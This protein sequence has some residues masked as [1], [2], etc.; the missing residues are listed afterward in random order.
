MPVTTIEIAIHSLFDRCNKG[1]TII[2]NFR[3]RWLEHFSDA[4]YT[5]GT[6][7]WYFKVFRNYLIGITPGIIGAVNI[8]CVYKGGISTAVGGIAS[9]STFF[10]GNV[11]ATVGDG[12]QGGSLDIRDAVNRKGIVGCWREAFWIQSVSESPDGVIFGTV[13]IT[14]A[15]DHSSCS[16]GIEDGSTVHEDRLNGITTDILNDL[17]GWTADI[18]Q[19]GH[20]GVT[21]V[22]YTGNDI[23]QGNMEGERPSMCIISAVC[24][25]IIV[26]DVALA[27]V[28][29]RTVNGDM[30]CHECVAAGVGDHGHGDTVGGDGGSAVNSSSTVSSRDSEVFWNDVIDVCPGVCGVIDS[31]VE[32]IDRVT[33]SAIVGECGVGER[34][35]YNVAA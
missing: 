2:L 32:G 19:A 16:I 31:V 12:R 4:L 25:W 3:R 22:W 23:W 30:A 21:I 14:E 28:V 10:Q 15:E 34:E 9:V 26:Y 17:C 5:Y 7:R 27:S 35:L 13:G 18:G 1:T 11:G 6:V 8:V 24:I 29:A 33:A 20:G